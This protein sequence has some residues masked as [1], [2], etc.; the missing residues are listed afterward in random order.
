M[1]RRL[2]VALALVAALL[3][4]AAG[5]APAASAAAAVSAANGTVGV[6]QTVAVV[7]PGAAGQQVTLL[8]LLGGTPQGQLTTTLDAQGEGTIPWVPT[9][10]GTWTLRGLAGVPTSATATVVVAP[11]P[12][13]TTVLTPTAVGLGLAT[14]L[15]ATVTPT[16]G[17]FIPQ[18]TLTF[19][20]VYGPVLGTTTVT[21][22]TDGQAVGS[23]SW[24][25]TTLG[26]F[27]I[28]ARFT[29]SGGGSTGSSAGAELY[30]STSLPTLRMI[31]PSSIILGQTIPLTA[32][33]A[34][35]LVPGTTAFVT[36][37]NG[38]TTSLAPSTTV[39][40]G[41]TT[42]QWTPSTA[43][44]QFVTAQFSSTDGNVSGAFTQGVAVQMPW[45]A[46]PLSVAS[47]GIGTLSTAAATTVRGGQRIGWATSTGS[48]AAVN[49]AESGPCLLDGA[50][51]VTPRAGGTCLVTATSTGGGTLG[52][53][54]AT[55]TILV[56][57]A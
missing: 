41:R 25:P 20:S 21:P 43:G 35:P 37:R 24:T 18:G 44:N 36:T 57:K 2:L 28:V 6:V 34:D 54:S 45:P 7:A 46:D 12:T 48:G 11:V 14:T 50:V 10:A 15:T 9:A 38:V 51:L 1:L 39:V 32:V 19:A 40:A 22:G 27:P 17:A 13:R 47:A 23:V 53:N 31:V 4:I 49:L 3:G 16:G 8:V 55:F 29:P 26:P 5:P 42:L 56:T 30:V 52:P 33:V